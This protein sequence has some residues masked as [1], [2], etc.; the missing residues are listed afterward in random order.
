MAN[1]KR[2]NSFLLLQ[3]F[4]SFLAL[5]FFV[6]MNLKK[7][8][9]YFKPLHYNY[10]KIWVL[11]LDL[12]KVPD[13]Q[14]LKFSNLVKQQLKNVKEIEGISETNAVPFHNW[15]D[16]Q[17]I[18]YN[19]QVT[20]VRAF[21]VDEEYE[22]V[23]GL[24]MLKGRWFNRSDSSLYTKPVVITKDLAIQQFKDIDPLGRK[25]LIEGK[26]AMVIGISETFRENVSAFAEPGFFIPREGVA[27]EFLI[28]SSKAEDIQLM[29]EKVRKAV[30]AVSPDLIQI[31][32]SIS[33]SLLKKYAH[34][35]D[36]MQLAVAFVVFVFL[37]INVFLGVSGM[38]SYNIAQRKAEVGL[39]VAMG[40]NAIDILKQFLG[41][42]MVVT[43]LGIFPGLLIAINLIALRYFE[44]YM[45]VYYGTLG[46]L[47]SALF[48]YLLM[49]SCAV[50]PSLKA[51][52]IQPAYV[53]H[54]D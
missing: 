48:L 16:E 15:G 28:K 54:E 43:T 33:L 21:A 38:F 31:K 5:F 44:P 25:I 46:I 8:S 30:M 27:T 9:H 39:R 20:K 41:E 4:I 10:E 18:E 19:K 3:L 11:D 32:Q 17:K 37:V 52:R 47:I 40:A 36:Y 1:R 42:T 51:S 12:T 13:D 34:K 45:D 53:L 2:K 49:L 26:P 29:D 6:G 22:K 50:Y 35:L 24:E 14:R 23:M 7:F